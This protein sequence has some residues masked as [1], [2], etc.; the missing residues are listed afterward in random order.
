MTTIDIIIIGLFIVT[1]IAGYRRG[2]IRQI[3]TVAGVVAGIAACRCLSGDFARWLEARDFFQMMIGNAPE[4]VAEHAAGDLSSTLLFVGD[5]RSSDCDG[6]GQGCGPWCGAW[7][8]RLL[9]WHD[10]QCVCR[11][12]CAQH[13][14]KYLPGFQAGRIGY[15]QVDTC[16]WQ[17][18]RGGVESG[19]SHVWGG[20]GSFATIYAGVKTMSNLPVLPTY[21]IK[22]I[23]IN[24]RINTQRWVMK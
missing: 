13:H 5:Y 8:C 14:S 15:R 12:S 9:S 4:L 23:L 10:D 22:Q 3:G 1:A 18:G 19:A 24:R 11:F 21:R 2:I 17:G 20:Y 7:F 6:H 16:R